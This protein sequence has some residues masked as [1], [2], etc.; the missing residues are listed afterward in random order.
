MVVDDKF[1][2]TIWILRHS[3]SAVL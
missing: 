3:T 2:A 1:G